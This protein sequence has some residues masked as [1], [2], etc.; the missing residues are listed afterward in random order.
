[1]SK[2]ISFVITLLSTFLL[3]HAFAKGDPLSPKEVQFNVEAEKNR[4]R[5]SLG[6][7]SSF[8]SFTGKVN[9]D[10]VRMRLQP[11]LDGFIVRELN[12]N[13]LLTVT[14]Q[15]GDYYCIEPPESLK[16]YI[17]RSF[18][19]DN[20]VEGNRVNIRLEPD[21]DS[22][23]IGHLNSG[24]RVDGK[25]SPQNKKWL[26]IPP[27]SNTYFYVA[28]EYVDQAGGPELKEKLA[29]RQETVEQLLEAANLLA[30]SEIRKPFNEINFEQVKQGYLTILHD[31]NDFPRMTELAKE[32]LLKIQEEYLQKR[33]NHLE[34]KAAL[35]SRAP[36]ENQQ[37]PTTP[38]NDLRN[39]PLRLA[40]HVIQMWEPIEE[41]LYANWAALNDNKDKDNYYKEQKLVA[42][43][44]SGVLEVYRTPIRNR[45]G[46]YIV[47]NKN[48]PIAYV[49]STKV[50]LEDYV[51][52]KI[53]LIAS[54]RP[55]NNFAFPAYFVHEVE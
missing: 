40:H 1:M 30:K 26:E 9:G 50:D 7:R 48:L 33:I 11:D 43:S 36:S 20:V 55:N 25:V 18:V 41:A 42:N 19:L 27:P 53:T 54:P 24:D 12:K 4:Q 10:K 35:A 45:P 2:L 3:T 15:E 28:K 14:N 32:S 5:K 23:V 21:L 31:Y 46:D 38:S 52:K 34:E 29:K 37:T 16:A 44:I 13:E 49:Y 6:T 17:F 47:K 51:G 22:P 8:S 39:E